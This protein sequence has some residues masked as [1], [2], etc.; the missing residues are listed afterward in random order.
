MSDSQL[1][2]P[3]L[4]EFL[5]QDVT[6]TGV[7]LGRGSYGHVEELCWNG[8]KCA[9]KCLHDALLEERTGSS[10]SAMVKSTAASKFVSECK[11]MAKIRHPN[12]VQFLGLCFFLDY[13]DQQQLFLVLEK[14]NGNLC[15]YLDNHLNVE[16]S[17]KCSVLLDVS[18][19]LVHLHS[20]DPPI[21][22]RDLTT[23]NIL[24][25]ASLQAKIADLGTAHSHKLALR[26]HHTPMP[27]TP[28]FMPPEANTS[29]PVYN[30]KLDIFSFGQVT[31]HTLT[32][33][34]P[35]ELLPQKYQTSSD[36]MKARTELERRSHYLDIL[37]SQLQKG[38]PLCKLTVGC[39][40]EMPK[41]RP[42]AKE[43]MKVLEEF[44]LELDN[45]QKRSRANSSIV[46]GSTRVKEGQEEKEAELKLGDWDTEQRKRSA[47]FIESHILVSYSGLSD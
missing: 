12:I 42:S 24:L 15:D 26:M 44:W 27:G 47:T 40:A 28:V 19:G 17:V 34:C 25:T 36:K 30:S 37:Y 32:Q 16:L 45:T 35:A 22:H 10:L 20:H 5:L 14:L 11:I 38:H 18:R 39:L 8:T 13:R 7:H 33:V 9:G 3:E 29:K 43:V 31:L 41:K 1:Q 23:R 46:P 21:I 2:H 6:R 4:Q